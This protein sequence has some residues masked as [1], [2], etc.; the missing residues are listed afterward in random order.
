MAAAKNQ[1]Q[2]VCGEQNRE[3]IEE[4]RGKAEDRRRKVVTA[5]ETDGR[6]TKEDK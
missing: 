3:R 6:G 4:G 2:R 1:G 5:T